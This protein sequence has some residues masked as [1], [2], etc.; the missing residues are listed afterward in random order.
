VSM[1]PFSSLPVPVPVPIS[2]R[3]CDATREGGEERREEW[4]ASVLARR[5]GEVELERGGAQRRGR[6]AGRR[7]PSPSPLPIFLS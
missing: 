1:L 7:L 3:G 6:Q 2:A 5:I 4:D